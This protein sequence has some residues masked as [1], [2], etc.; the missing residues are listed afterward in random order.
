M[1]SRRLLEL[2]VSGC[3]CWLLGSKQATVCCLYI[4]GPILSIFY[5]HGQ[6]LPVQI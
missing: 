2:S 5:C 4:C 1:V 3:C 6:I